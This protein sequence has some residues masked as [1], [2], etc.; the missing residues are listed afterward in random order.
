VRK[1][2]ACI[3]FVLTFACLGLLAGYGVGQYRNRGGSVRWEIDPLPDDARAVALYAG[4]FSEVVVES[5]QGR[6]YAQMC[7]LTPEQWRWIPDMIG[8]DEHTRMCGLRANLSELSIG[9][10][11]GPVTDQLDCQITLE[12]TDVS[13]RYVILENGELWRWHFVGP[14]LQGVLEGFGSTLCLAIG[15][16]MLGLITYWTIQR[17]RENEVRL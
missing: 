15:G 12:Y 17:L 2:A 16:G 9:K 5:D 7:T 11:P 6:F 3:I 4:P 10:P 8:D 14:G 13:C 1:P